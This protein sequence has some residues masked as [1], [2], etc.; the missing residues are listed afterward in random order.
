MGT[1]QERDL[2]VAAAQDQ[3]LDARVAAAMNL[4]EEVLF[5]AL[6]A[7]AMATRHGVNLGQK[8]LLGAL[9]A[10]VK[11]THGGFLDREELPLAALGGH[12]PASARGV[13]L[14][15]GELLEAL[16]AQAMAATLEESP[17]GATVLP[18]APGEQVKTPTPGTLLGGGSASR[19]ISIEDVKVVTPGTL[20]GGATVV[21]SAANEEVRTTTS[22]IVAVLSESGRNLWR[23]IEGQLHELTCGSSTEWAPDRAKIQSAMDIGATE[24]GIAIATAIGTIVVGG[25]PLVPAAL[26]A[27]VAALVIKILYKGAW[28][29]T[30]DAWKLPQP[31]SA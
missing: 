13:H 7:H 18:G 24:A 8:V 16:G 28:K 17:R 30:C 15:E 23:G 14:E 4:D 3:D 25:I 10:H 22:R 29:A 9:S 27:F 26:V 5:G 21:P 20:L 2:R 11:A 6:G 12:L 19:G 1:D 31:T